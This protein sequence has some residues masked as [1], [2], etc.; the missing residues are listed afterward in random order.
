MPGISPFT[1]SPQGKK[2]AVSL[3]E[4]TRR[5]RTVE[6]DQ[7]KLYTLI[8]DPDDN[9]DVLVIPPVVVVM[10]TSGLISAGTSL[11]AYGYENWGSTTAAG[12]LSAAR[13]G[14]VVGAILGGL[15]FAAFAIT[16]PIIQNALSEL[17][18]NPG[19]EQVLSDAVRS[20][21]DTLESFFTS[22]SFWE[23]LNPQTYIALF[24]DIKNDIQLCL[25]GVMADFHD[26]YDDN[27]DYDNSVC[28]L[29]S[30]TARTIIIDSVP[31]EIY[32]DE[33]AAD[34]EI[35]LGVAFSLTRATSVSVSL[36]FVTSSNQ[37]NELGTGTFDLEA[38]EWV[39]YIAGVEGSQFLD[40][41]GQTSGEF[42][43]AARMDLV[44][45]TA[46][47]ELKD[48]NDSRAHHF[49][50]LPHAPE[51][52]AIAVT[53]D[54]DPSSTTPYASVNVSG[55]AFYD[56]GDPVPSGTALITTSQDAWTAAVIDGYYDRYISAP[57]SSGWVTVQ[58]SDGLLT[59]SAQDHLTITLPGDGDNY[60]FDVALMCQDVES[61]DPWDPINITDWY[62]SSDEIA[63]SWLQLSYL[64]VPVKVEWRWFIPDGTELDPTYSAW[65]D[66]PQDFGYL[67][68]GWWRFWYGYYISGYAHS[69]WEGR[70]TVK[71]SVQEEGQSYDYIESL[72]YIISYDFKEH[73]MYK[74]VDDN[75][76]PSNPTNT[77]YQDDE[78]AVTWARYTDVV[79]SIELMTEFYEPNGSLYVDTGLTSEDPGEGYYLPEVWQWT[80][81][82]IDGNSAAYKCGSWTL[83]KYEKDPWGNW[84]L[85]YEDSFRILENPAVNPVVTLNVSPQ[86]PTGGEQVSLS[87]SA[88]DNT[89]LKKV[90]LYWNYTATDSI[91]W[92]NIY[93]GTFTYTQALGSFPEGAIVQVSAKA[94]DTSG[95]FGSTG[96]VIINAHDNDT[97]GPVISDV[98]ITEYNGDADGLIEPDEAVMI[99]CT[100]TDVSGVDAVTIEVD[101]SGVTLSGNYFSTSGPFAEGWHQVTIT[102]SDG[103]NTP[104]ETTETDSF[105]V[106]P[107]PIHYGDVSL[108]GGVSAYDAALVLQ[109]VAGIDTL[110]VQAQRNADVSCDGSPSAFDA[111]IILK[112]VVGIINTLPSCGNNQRLLA[113]GKISLRDG[114]IRPG[115]ILEI[116]LYIFEAKDIFSFEGEIL[117]D[118]LI[119][120]YQGIIWSEAA[121]DFV[122]EENLMDGILR[123]AGAGTVAIGSDGV[124]SKLQFMG[125][126]DFNSTT[127][128]QLKRLR[129]NEG[130]I[131]EDV[132]AATFTHTLSGEELALLIPLEYGLDQN[133][134][135]PFNPGTVIPYQLP[136]NGYVTLSIY[137]LHG[138]LVATVIEGY[139]NSG[140][141]TAYWD[142][143]H[144]SSGVYIYRI[145]TGNYSQARKCILIK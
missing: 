134:P 40:L 100:V 93:A 84:D 34:D 145:T 13:D 32:D 37:Y 17:L 29:N 44:G 21:F 91:I 130:E 27:Y 36:G 135:N 97:E 79:E 129:W 66:D 125:N 26:E 51:P 136:D 82:G 109:H 31:T 80:W 47:D 14:F 73:R 74:V 140:F 98:S 78:K 69:D 120:S 77:F 38:G 95:D 112:Y 18:S 76:N 62:R 118:P 85:L 53:V 70:H 102:A 124:F 83:K 63:Y 143:T 111:S 7:W 35:K 60:T 24:V 5:L 20:I 132:A 104:A 22:F 110:D 56:T 117:F 94:W 16:S 90:G 61:A 49:T 99:A 50:I 92:D 10:A 42:A 64:Y 144:A 41:V 48:Y 55:S 126:S 75:G 39:A 133:Y 128:V 113:S 43:A 8:Y 1:I 68:W 81:I 107:L 116:P 46:F 131:M 141:Y 86:I 15:K 30:F 88:S 137:D 138:R 58:V 65:T 123:I 89:Y 142:A 121:H 59:G 72:E 87:L 9:I 119:L 57:G 115:E 127:R 52:T 4:L 122:I 11:I 71:V 108:D 3:E 33:F 114:E 139:Q 25:V 67:Y 96:D 23:M 101:G 19:F 105:E 12:W 6:E 106:H 103:D 54:L 2:T 45:E 28:I